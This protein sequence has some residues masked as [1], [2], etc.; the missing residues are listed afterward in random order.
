MWDCVAVGVKSLLSGMSYN[1]HFLFF[2]R[3]A[4]ALHMFALTISVL[5]LL[6]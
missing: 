2:A 5:S 3:G 1:L 4:C 6:L